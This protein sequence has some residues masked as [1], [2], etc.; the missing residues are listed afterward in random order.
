LGKSIIKSQKSPGIVVHSIIP[1][2]WEEKVRDHSQRPD[3]E[4]SR[5]PI[6]KQTKAKG[7]GHGSSGKALAQGP[8]FKPSTT[9]EILKNHNFYNHC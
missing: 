3:Q 5:D 6:Q 8:D 2:A 9:K 7:L 4:K 1:A